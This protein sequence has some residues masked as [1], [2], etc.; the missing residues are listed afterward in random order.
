MFTEAAIL[1]VILE[2]TRLHIGAL[3]ALFAAAAAWVL[4]S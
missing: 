2:G 1:P 3:V 4:L